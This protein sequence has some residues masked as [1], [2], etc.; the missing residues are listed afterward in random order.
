MGRTRI[1]SYKH[2][3]G[4]SAAAPSADP[5]LLGVGVL[6]T[7]LG[8][9]EIV[10]LAG[11][12]FA[13][14]AR[15]RSR[16]LALV[17][18]AGGSPAHLRRIVLADGALLGLVGA[19][20]GLT[21]GVLVAFAARGLLEE[22]F[23]DARAGGYRV[24]PLALAGITALAVLTGV[25]AAL[26]PAFTAARQ[27]VVQGLTGRRGAVRS[28]RRW[29]LLGTALLL[30]GG[31]LAG[32][33]ALRVNTYGLLGGLILAQLGLA[34]GIQALIGRINATIA[35]YKMAASPSSMTIVTTP[36]LRDASGSNGK[37]K[38]RN[39]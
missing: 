10:L 23:F 31:A 11:P 6:L 2:F 12:A 3:C 15:R 13:V 4:A 34:I 32:Y 36:S 16:E 1:P 14:G 30:A 21:V 17:A 29:I 5:K 28:R 8:M 26:I 38:R 33:S 25:A 37:L 20:I 7:G 19:L 24:W 27:S 9:L 18:A 39:P 22:Q 35:P